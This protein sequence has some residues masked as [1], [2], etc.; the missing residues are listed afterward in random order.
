MTKQR[1][2]S[3]TVVLLLSCSVLFGQ[4]YKLGHVNTQE[5]M[6]AMPESDSAKMRMEKNRKELESQLEQMQVELNKKYENYLENQD[7]YSKLVRQ[8]KETELQELNQ[9]IQQFQISAEQDLQQQRTSLFEPIYNKMNEA[10]SKVG[11]E[12]GYTYIFD[13]STGGV[14]YSAEDADD[15]TSLVKKELRIE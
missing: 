3:F 8:T 5:I 2:I 11:Q 14:A 4:K 7:N 9:R 12:N 1:I 10:I 15:L 6:T 13:T